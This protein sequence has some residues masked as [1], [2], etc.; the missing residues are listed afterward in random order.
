MN[1][2]TE[3]GL[4]KRYLRPKR[5]AI[6]VITCISV[7]GVTLGVMVLIVVLSVMNG[8]S[9]LRKSLLLKTTPHLEISPP[10]GQV[11]G[12][13]ESIIEIVKRQGGGAAAI[14]A[15]PV[16]IQTEKRLQP[17]LAIGADYNQVK[18]WIKIDWELNEFPVGRTEEGKQPFAPK[19][20]V[21]SRQTAQELM[22][23]YESRVVLHSPER[24]NSMIEI[25]ADGNVKAAAEREISVPVELTVSGFFATGVREFDES[26]VFI[27]LD[28]A[29][30][31]FEMPMGSADKIYGWVRNPF[32][33]DRDFAKIRSALPEGYTVKSWM[34]IH[35]KLLGVLQVEK[36]MMFFLLF[37]V[38]LVAA[39]SITNTLITVVHQKTREIGLL[40][41]L[42]ATPGTIMRIFIMQ[43]TVV[44]LIGGVVGS[45]CGI[46][47][48]V[49][50][51]QLMRLF[52]R[53]TGQDLFSQEFYV[54]SELPARLVASDIILIALIAVVLCT[55]GALLP[56]IRAARLDPAR[57]LRYE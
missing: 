34:E 31:L 43:G 6:S 8:L 26:T 38:V 56:A 27:N 30:D 54:I 29:C 24:L 40:N 39:F 17:R 36:N 4:A 19:T 28:D 41:S 23:H 18:D 15:R 21:I 42:G 12:N 51:N 55:L 52:S 14:V 20:I 53:L 57:A 1:L 3:L 45:V 2:W 22:V 44:G 10:A 7:L 48:V 5:N 49:W 16:V 46:L 33:L 35:R 37:F 13:P 32:E 47:V 11:I 9:D 25:D 50:R